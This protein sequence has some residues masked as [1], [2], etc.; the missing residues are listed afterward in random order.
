MKV[1]YY[2][3]S[4][5]GVGCGGS[6][7]LFDPFISA[8]EKAEGIKIKDIRPGYIL[9]THGHHDHVADALNISRECNATI[10]SNY[11]IVTWFGA[12]GWEKGHAM[13]IGGSWKFPFGRVKVVNAIHSSTLPDGRNG[14]NPAGFVVKTE[15]GSFYHAGDTA[16]TY[17]M[18]LIGRSYRLKFAMLPLGDNFTMGIVDAIKAAGFI[19]CREII[20]MH[21][22]TFAPIVIDHARAK[23][24]FRDAGMNLRLLEIGQTVEIR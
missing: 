8:N 7:L 23:K 14:G 10:V 13:N 15:E 16:L 24:K 22:D 11:E 21:Y 1:T 12:Q 6:S 20:G 9:I 19:R 2:G 17:D 5:F 18:R 4:C 3:H